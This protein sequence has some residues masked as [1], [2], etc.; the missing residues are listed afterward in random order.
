MSKVLIILFIV[1]IT[2]ACVK[3]KT[4][5]YIGMT[6][7]AVAESWGEPDL[8]RRMSTGSVDYEQWR[9]GLYG[10]SSGTRHFKYLYFE[11]GIL[12]SVTQ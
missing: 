1:L 7:K 8:I 6:D 10:I 11:N 4:P 5:I 9:Y 12:K 2:I 3:Q